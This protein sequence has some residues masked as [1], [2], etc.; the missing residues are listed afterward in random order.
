LL[1][2]KQQHC[3][4]FGNREV[5]KVSVNSLNTLTIRMFLV[6]GRMEK[7]I[8]A[9]RKACNLKLISGIFYLMF[10]SCRRPWVTGTKD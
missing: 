7:D 8:S 6:L 4:I 9:L 10:L 1:E 3:Q 5:Y 2:D